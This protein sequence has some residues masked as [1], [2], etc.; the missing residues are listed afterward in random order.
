[1]GIKDVREYL[2]QWD[3]EKDILEFDTSS[4]T[5]ELAAQA[6]GVEPA[7]IAKTLAFKNGEGALLVVAAGDARVDN[8]KFKQ[9]FGFKPHML[10]PDEALALTGHPVGGVC[11]FGLKQDVPVF[12]DVSLKRFDTVF[13][14]CGSSNSAIELTCEELDLYSRNVR[15][16]DVCRGW[17]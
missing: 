7:R 9:E 14:A 16:V 5:V 10:S 17:A 12:C 4:A 8:K 13:P 2:R 1:M 11:P 3:R 6:V 15:W